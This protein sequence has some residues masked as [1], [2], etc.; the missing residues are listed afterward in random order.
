M[1][2]RGGIEKPSFALPVDTGKPAEWSDAILYQ[3]PYPIGDEMGGQGTTGN[4]VDFLTILK[5]ILLDDGKLLKSSTIKDMFTQQLDPAQKAACTAYH[6]MPYFVGT[7]GSQKQGSDFGWG[8][9]GL[10]SDET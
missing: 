9:A 3:D 1:R 4:A 7:F 5:S 6:E 8:L 2:Q 10:I